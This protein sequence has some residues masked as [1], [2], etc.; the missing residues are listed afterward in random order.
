MNLPNVL[1]SEEI[2]W[3]FFFVSLL[4]C[5]SAYDVDLKKLDGLAKAKVEVGLSKN[6]N[7][8]AIR[9]VNKATSSS[10]R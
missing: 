10:L 6:I 5:V 2:M 9:F 7:A 4:N 1:Q 8:I 3:F